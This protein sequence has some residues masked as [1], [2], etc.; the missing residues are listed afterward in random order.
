MT[1]THVRL[2][3]TFFFILSGESIP[4]SLS[5]KASVFPV[6]PILISNQNLFFTI[7]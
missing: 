7:A 6:D 1:C 2:L 5:H 3:V 4:R